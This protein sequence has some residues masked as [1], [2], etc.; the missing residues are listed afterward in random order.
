MFTRGTH[1][2]NLSVPAELAVEGA[3][4]VTILVVKRF[5]E[6]EMGLDS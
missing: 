2:L 5:T 4:F 3:V 1:V 6:E